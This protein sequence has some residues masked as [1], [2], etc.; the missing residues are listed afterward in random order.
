MGSEY[1]AQTVTAVSYLFFYRGESLW[2]KKAVGHA[3][4]L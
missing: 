1:V 3:G 2:E 4:K